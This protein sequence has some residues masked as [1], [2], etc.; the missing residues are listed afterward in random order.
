MARA[1][2]RSTPVHPAVTSVAREAAAP[3]VERL[4]DRAL[5]SNSAAL[6]V[7]VAAAASSNR[8]PTIS[9]T[10]DATDTTAPAEVKLRTTVSDPDGDKIAKVDFYNGSKKISTDKSAPYRFNVEDLGAGT[11]Q[12]T[13]KA[14]DS[15]GK[16]GT[17]SALT[18]VVTDSTPTP[19][20]T[21]MNRMTGRY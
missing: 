2:T 19:T 1:V 8:A 14:T 12:F 11:Y 18:V 7:V 15:K 20:P 3:L 5:F 6:P 10:N 16:V 17:S 9:L 21:R 4:E 13:A